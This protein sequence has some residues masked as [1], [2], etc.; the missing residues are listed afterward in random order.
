MRA[1]EKKNARL[2]NN[3][4][5]GK[6]N[7]QEAQRRADLSAAQ[8]D[9]EKKIHKNGN[10]ERRKKDIKDLFA[11]AI[12]KEIIFASYETLLRAYRHRNFVFPDKMQPLLLSDIQGW[13]QGKN[14]RKNLRFLLRQLRE[15]L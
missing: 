3:G 1:A 15:E 2:R 8:N 11:Y 14:K 4:R 7:R 6:N 5:A 10:Q 12:R 13:V 9:A